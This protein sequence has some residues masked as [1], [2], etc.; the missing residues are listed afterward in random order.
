MTDFKYNNDLS[1]ETKNQKLYIFLRGEGRRLLQSCLRQSTVCGPSPA[2]NS[3]G[4]SN[5]LPTFLPT[6]PSL[7]LRR[8]SDSAFD[9]L[10]LGGQISQKMTAKS[11]F[12]H[13]NVAERRLRRARLHGPCRVLPAGGASGGRTPG[14][15]G[16]IYGFA[17]NWALAAQVFP[18]NTSLWS[19]RLGQLPVPPPQCCSVLAEHHNM[20]CGGTASCGF[21]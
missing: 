16:P 14:G 10:S 12:L 9:S 2:F 17:I 18:V 3:P 6:C 4:F 21:T 5:N 8:L 7:R 1:S 20:P 19:H 13:S 15:S 11:P